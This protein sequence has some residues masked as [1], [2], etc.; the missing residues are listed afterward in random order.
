MSIFAL[1]PRGVQAIVVA[2]IAAVFGVSIALWWLAFF[3]PVAFVWAAL[4]SWGSAT[5]TGILLRV[6]RSR[7]RRWRIPRAVARERTAT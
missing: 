6:R 2:I 5:I 7:A 4:I 3:H 1:L